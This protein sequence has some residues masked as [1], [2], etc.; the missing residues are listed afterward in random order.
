MTNE[1][2]AARSGARWHL[3][4]QRR[5]RARGRGRSLP[6]LPGREESGQSRPLPPLAPCLRPPL[7]SWHVPSSQPAG[8]AWSSE[9]PLRSCPCLALLCLQL[10]PTRAPHPAPKQP[11]PAA[12]GWLCS[13][14]TR[15][16]DKP[17]PGRAPV[18]APSPGTPQPTAGARRGQQDWQEEAGGEG[19]AWHWQPSSFHC[20]VDTSTGG[21]SCHCQCRESQALPQGRRD[22]TSSRRQSARCPS[23]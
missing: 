3:P 15:H 14:L 12:H 5:P 18:S 22:G 7:S 17:R 16:G 9:D 11:L 6:H 20:G 8:R 1:E 10:P 2:S 4:S 21:L 13:R 19:S 23:P